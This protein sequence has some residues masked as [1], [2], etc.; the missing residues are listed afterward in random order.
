M[1]KKY[2]L[3]VEGNNNLVPSGEG[4]WHDVLVSLTE[5]EIGRSEYHSGPHT[6]EDRENMGGKLLSIYMK[7]DFKLFIKYKSEH[8]YKFYILPQCIEMSKYTHM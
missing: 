2:V 1:S 7:K 4:T 3:L 6:Q 8:G 5:F